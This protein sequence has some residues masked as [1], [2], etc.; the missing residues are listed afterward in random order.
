M[1]AVFPPTPPDYYNK[2]QPEGLEK[3][4]YISDVGG[5]CLSLFLP[6]NKGW[7]YKSHGPK[8]ATTITQLQVASDHHGPETIYS[9]SRQWIIANEVGST[10]INSTLTGPKSDN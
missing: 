1:H 10:E 4:P 2:G 5:L 6:L 7:T 9:A 3:N 8:P